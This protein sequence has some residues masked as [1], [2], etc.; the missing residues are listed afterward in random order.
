MQT[1]DR[2]TIAE[3][4]AAKFAATPPDRLSAI[5]AVV[6]FDG[7]IDSIIRVVDRR[8]S[9][10]PDDF[11]PVTTIT[12]FADRCAA[13][14]GK[15][16]NLEMH[17]VERRFGGNG[18]LL[19]SA[20]ASLGASVTYIGAVGRGDSPT[21]LHPI[22]QPLADRCAAVYPVAAAAKTDALEFDDG[23]LMLGK[24]E[25]VQAVCWELL[26][27]IVGLDQ[28]RSIF[29]RASTIGIVNWVM[30]QG[31]EG[32]WRGLIDEVLP[33]LSGETPRKMFVDLC[34][35]AKRTDE[36]VRRAAGFLTEL[37]AHVNLT[38]GLN[39][40]EAE[41]MG[42]V[43]GVDIYEGPGNQ[44]LG[45]AMQH[46]AAS[47]RESL[48]IAC[49]VVHPREG[50]AAADA[51]GSAWFEGPFTVKPKISTG[52]GDHFNG[53]FALAQDLGLGLDECLAVGC[54]LSGAYVRD[55]ASPARER[56]IEFLR[57]LPRSQAS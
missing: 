14:A 38:L 24:T 9:M 50:A 40:S 18:P 12:G 32:I 48:G 19:A 25:S 10:Q 56:L 11:L 57:D 30:L 44:S 2:R 5:N 39:Q 3:S 42:R 31:V 33:T 1:R 35:P 51:N 28:L 17:V 52:A 6:G 54:A 29:E 55:A 37:N 4:A 43:L 41:R 13:A 47:I 27:D 45:S 21:N 34:D 36:D 26:K 15:S 7:F 16:T 49:C 46:A 8:H 23:K 20:M 53:G 22:Y